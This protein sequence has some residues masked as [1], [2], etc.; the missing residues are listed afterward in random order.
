MEHA[1]L[2]VDIAKD[3]FEAVLLQG[4]LKASCSFSNNRSGFERLSDWLASQGVEQAYAC[5]EATGRYWEALAYYLREK[6]HLVSVVNP[7]RIHH[8]AKSQ[9]ARN[10]TDGMD[11]Q[12]IARFCQKE[13]PRIWQPLPE[14][15]R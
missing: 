10:K 4:E 12:I 8:Y 9:L 11:A 6:D 14:E 3:S 13:A 7:S 1:I 5:M 2:G 15:L